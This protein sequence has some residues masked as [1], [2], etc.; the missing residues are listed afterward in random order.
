MLTAEDLKNGSTEDYIRLATQYYGLMLGGYL[1]YVQ[2][3]NIDLE[4]DNILFQTFPAFLND[5]EI[6]ALGQAIAAAVRPYL[7]QEPSPER[8]RYVFG[9][10]SFPDVA[11]APAP[12]GAQG[13]SSAVKGRPRRRKPKKTK[14]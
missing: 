13:R 2:A 1:R 3:G 10:T 11:S 7:K 8:R 14:R 9:L 6:Q 5:K 4:R 12:A